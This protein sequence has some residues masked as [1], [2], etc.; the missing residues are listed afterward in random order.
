MGPERTPLG[1]DLPTSFMSP[2]V[3]PYAFHKGNSGRKTLLTSQADHYPHLFPERNYARLRRRTPDG[4]RR[5]SIEG[6][7]LGPH[8]LAYPERITRLS[9]ASAVEG[10]QAQYTHDSLY[11]VYVFAGIK[12]DS[13]DDCFEGLG[14]G[15]W[16][17][18]TV[19]RWISVDVGRD[20]R[21]IAFLSKIGVVDN[22]LDCN[23]NH[24]YSG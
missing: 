19:L 1:K 7:H 5:S 10:C 11:Y 3:E 24:T 17:K 9:L 14:A 21:I 6:V 2:A 8:A 16:G 20:S 12:V 23:I 4:A 22:R 18:H 13:A 15:F